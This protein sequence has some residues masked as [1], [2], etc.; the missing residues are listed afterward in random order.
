[1]EL[2][3]DI[4]KGILDELADS[5]SCSG[6]GKVKPT[7]VQLSS[8]FSYMSKRVQSFMFVLIWSFD[9][10]DTQQVI[11]FIKSYIDTFLI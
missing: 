4:L 8:I 11:I 9:G 6:N 7:R 1:M 10:I 5:K 2:Y 3:H